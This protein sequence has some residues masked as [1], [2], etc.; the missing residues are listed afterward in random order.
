MSAVL[1]LTM[2]IARSSN[3]SREIEAL[4]IEKAIFS[5]GL[6]FKFN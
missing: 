3:Y 5:D 2:L 6:S 4:K 1:V